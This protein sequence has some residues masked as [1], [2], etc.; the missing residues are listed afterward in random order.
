MGEETYSV[1]VHECLSTS[2]CVSLDVCV[3]VCMCV[4]VCACR[5]IV[6]LYSMVRDKKHAFNALYFNSFSLLLLIYPS[7]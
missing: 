5:A 7:Q 6:F 1:C 4:S 2:E 3:Y